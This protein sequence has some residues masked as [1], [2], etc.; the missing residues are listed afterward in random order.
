MANL[1]E[2]LS[3]ADV[4]KMAAEWHRIDLSDARAA[5]LADELNG[6]NAATRAAAQRLPYDVEP[7][8]FTSALTKLKHK[9][10]T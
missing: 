8:A 7:A 10:R 9:G 4:K 6:L 2:G 1:G 3:G 5:G